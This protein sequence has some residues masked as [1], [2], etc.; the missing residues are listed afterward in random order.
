MR[1]IVGLVQDAWIALVADLGILPELHGQNSLIELD[2]SFYPKRVIH[3]DFQSIYSDQQIRDSFGL[4]CFEKHIAG[5]EEG[6]T[7]SSQYS[8]VY[9]GMIGRFLF[10]RLVEAFCN[11]YDYSVENVQYAIKKRFLA[12][13]DNYSGKF[14]DTIYSFDRHASE[15]EGNDIGLK[16]TGEC[17]PYR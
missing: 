17:P 13:S 8:L 10:D 15:Q 16:D 9:D 2:E 14:P 6:T 1:I 11:H 7:V 4:P 5:L 12:F 3:R